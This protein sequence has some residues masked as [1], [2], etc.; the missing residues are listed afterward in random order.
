MDGSDGQ[1]G[2]SFAL[3]SYLTG[4]LAKFLDDLRHELA[5]GC[6]ARAHVTV[7]PPRRLAASPEAVWR[8][9]SDR[10]QDCAPFDVE[11]GGAEIFPISKVIYVSV[12]QGFARL[13]QLHDQLNCGAAHFDEPF[14]YH[15]HITL[16]Q[17]LPAD[18]VRGALTLASE[19]WRESGMPHTFTVG[20]LAF[21]QSTPDKRWRDL[22]TVDLVGHAVEEIR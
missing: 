14:E 7:L 2:E 6:F 5:P 15:P 19:R 18:A 9:L 10:V 20:K 17:D 16:A 13:H 3:V 22:Y 12:K 1:G 21:V 8:D 4:P 11:L